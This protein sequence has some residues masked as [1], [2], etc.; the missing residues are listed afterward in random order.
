MKK[1]EENLLVADLPFKNGSSKFSKYKANNKTRNLVISGR[2]K[3]HHV[4]IWVSRIE[5][6]S[7]FK[8]SKLYFM[9]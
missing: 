3:E 1:N 5:L 8:L 6:F 4:K 2:K 7:P 9:V